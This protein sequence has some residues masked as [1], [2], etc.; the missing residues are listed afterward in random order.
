MAQISVIL[1]SVLISMLYLCLGRHEG[2]GKLTVQNCWAGRS[3]FLHWLTCPKVSKTPIRIIRP[4]PS[5]FLL[6]LHSLSSC[7]IINSIIQS[8]ETKREPCR[9]GGCP[10]GREF[11]LQKQK[12][13]HGTE[14]VMARLCSLCFLC[15]R[16]KTTST[17]RGT[18]CWKVSWFINYATSIT[19]TDRRRT[20]AQ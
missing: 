15:C 20:P 7:T 14:R 12:R 16:S 18:A 17:L 11:R 8:A 2:V 3:Q 19:E 6:T 4:S 10:C 13:S 5:R 1:S 9:P